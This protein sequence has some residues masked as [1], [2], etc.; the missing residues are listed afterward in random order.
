VRLGR[1][2]RAAPPAARWA[3]GNRRTRSGRRLA[4]LSTASSDDGPG[5]GDTPLPASTARCTTT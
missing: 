2:G 1:R 4:T 5:T 3:P